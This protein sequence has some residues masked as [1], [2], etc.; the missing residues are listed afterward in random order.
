MSNRPYGRHAALA[1]AAAA[2]L[3][4][5]LGS[6]PRQDC[7]RPSAR[8]VESLFAP[9]VAEASKSSVIAILRGPEPVVA[10][11]RRE[12]ADDPADITGSTPRP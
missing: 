3:A 4:A 5:I 9:C 11:A 12:R 10:A 6:G 1:I 7:P 8:S 2:S